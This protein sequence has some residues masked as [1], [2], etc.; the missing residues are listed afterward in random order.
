MT[1]L[2][3]VPAATQILEVTVIAVGKT[4]GDGRRNPFL[5]TTSAQAR[6]GFPSSE[7]ERELS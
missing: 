7:D 6:S 3:G 4:E 5:P 1:G 2:C